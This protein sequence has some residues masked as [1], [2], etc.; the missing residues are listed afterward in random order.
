MICCREPC[1]VHWRLGS[2]CYEKLCMKSSSYG[3]L[4]VRGSWKDEGEE[5]DKNWHPG[6]KVKEG[7][8]T[9]TRVWK[10]SWITSEKYQ[11]TEGSSHLSATETEIQ[12]EERAWGVIYTG[13]YTQ[14]H[15]TI[16]LFDVS[17]FKLSEVRRMILRA[18]STSALR[19][20][21]I[22]NT[23][24][25]NCQSAG[26]PSDPMRLPRTKW[27]FHWSGKGQWSSPSLKRRI[28]RQPVQVKSV[29][30]TWRQDSLLSDG[31]KDGQKAN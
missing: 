28:A 27:V 15:W 19:P 3:D 14:A 22:L 30:I 12:G 25:K 16:S 9:I 26:T 1:V 2:T 8:S 29:W 23:L 13:L 10:F 5:E 17:L 24:Y 31:K 4:T 6:G 18:R 11:F 7:N 20:N 21:R